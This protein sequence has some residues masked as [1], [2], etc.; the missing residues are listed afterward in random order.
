MPRTDLRALFGA[1]QEELL[2]SLKSVSSVPH[3]T[4]QGDIREADWV[5]MLRDHLPQRYCASTGIVVDCEQQTSDQ[6]D[7]IIHDRQYSPLLFK[8]DKRLFVPAESV[9]AVFEVKPH[10]DSR[11][12]RYAAAKAES[13]RRLRRT[14]ASV[15]HAGGVI[16]KTKPPPEIL[17]GILGDRSSWKE[18]FGD[19]FRQALV[20]FN[21]LRRL[22]LGCAL[23]NG[24]FVCDSDSSPE[25]HLKIAPAE[26]ALVFF[27][28]SLLERLQQM[29][30]VPV[31]DYS[32][33]RRVLEEPG[34]E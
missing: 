6:I 12:L 30:T 23:S 26:T 19:K 32:A 4:M 22:D 29:G 3:P 25:P 16:Q 24:A 7:I 2:A 34:I 10:I 11:S 27:F 14:S 31:I 33:Y 17:A 15:H 28:M 8:K 9:Y 21:G 13:V 20:R 18:S 5:R 1:L